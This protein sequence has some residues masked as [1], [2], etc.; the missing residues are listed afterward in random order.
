LD[1]D[2]FIGW[3]EKVDS[4]STVRDPLGLWHHLNIQIDY[5][6]GITSGTSKIRYY[7][8]LCWYYQ[9]LFEHRIVNHDEFE[10]LFILAC[11][12]H[13]KGDY[14]DPGIRNL[15]N[16]QRFKDHWKDIEQFKL[17]FQINGFARTYYN[18]QISILRCC[19][20]DI[21]GDIHQTSI[22]RE[23]ANCLS[24]VDIDFFRNIIFTKDMVLTHMTDFCLCKHNDKEIEI[25]SQLLFGFIKNQDNDWIIDENSYT[26]FIQRSII[27][28]SF[29]GEKLDTDN[30]LE[31]SAFDE[32]SRRRRNTL[33]LFLKII[34]EVQP[35]T[36]DFKKAI[37]DALYFR[38]KIY[39]R[40]P[41]NF[42]PLSR[43]VDYWEFLQLNEYYVFAIE[44]I[45]DIIQ[46]KVKNNNGLP[47][48]SIFSSCDPLKIMSQIGTRT[49]TSLD[50]NLTLREMLAQAERGFAS[51]DESDAFDSIS[52]SQNDEETLGDLVI[53]LVL[54]KQRYHRISNEIKKASRNE[55]EYEIDNRLLIQDLFDFVEKNP[56][57][58]VIAFLSLIFAWV[59]RRHLYESAIRYRQNNT[60]NW[61]FVEDNGRLFFSR[62]RSIRIHPRDNRWDAIASLMKDIDMIQYG[63]NITLTSKG[64]LWLEK[65]GLT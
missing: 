58:K 35:S 61:L 38:R 22:N 27:D 41:I 21:L 10:R 57:M 42:N 34:N 65:A 23:L 60:K 50:L 46:N 8:L 45:L 13:H 59:V 31:E 24:A 52:S 63:T 44:I 1:R 11:L 51:F 19:W 49:K 29:E 40:G 47:M 12:S 26:D 5:T 17:D 64:I 43:V 7:T 48:D 56:D 15:F 53:L 14:K 39:T 2:Y 54:L 55:R 20:T 16:I 62:R 28:F 18:R 3:T 9:N 33:F 32:L 30:P 6:P 36:A 4:S 25:M 37:Y